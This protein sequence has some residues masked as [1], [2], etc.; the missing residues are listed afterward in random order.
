[1]FRLLVLV[2]CFSL[3]A[4]MMQSGE[5]L[6]SIP[7]SI[8]IWLLGGTDEAFMP[9]GLYEKVDGP[10]L[11]QTL[12]SILPYYHPNVQLQSSEDNENED[13]T[14]SSSDA[15]FRLE[16][17]V[18]NSMTTS[19]KKDKDNDTSEG[20]SAEKERYAYSERV[21]LM[22]YKSLIEAAPKD[23]HSQHHLLTVPQV[24]SLLT[25]LSEVRLEGLNQKEHNEKEE[26]E[27]KEEEDFFSIPPGKYEV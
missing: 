19:K 10:K 14:F 24:L 5:P 9:K 26:K 16:Y 17:K 12:S 6:L 25:Q 18:L 22:A 2:I 20:N 4:A 13:S 1:M 7:L 11:E 8:S 27:E 21:F 23:P 3:G 15:Q